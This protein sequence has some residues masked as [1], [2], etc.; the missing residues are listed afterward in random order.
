[1]LSGRA[2]GAL[3]L[4]SMELRKPVRMVRADAGSKRRFCDAGGL[5]SQ[6]IRSPVETAVGR[7]DR[8]KPGGGRSRFDQDDELRS[9]RTVVVVVVKRT[10]A[11]KTARRNLTPPKWQLP[12]PK[13]HPRLPCAQGLP[14][15]LRYPLPCSIELMSG[16]M[17][18]CDC[19]LVVTGR[20]S[21]R[22]PA[23]QPGKDDPAATNGVK[24]SYCFAA[25]GRKSSP[26]LTRCTVGGKFPSLRRPAVICHVVTGSGATS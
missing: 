21:L 3:W 20:A 12:T 23:R 2:V 26:A 18:W 14:P 22:P 25:I 6:M 15:T 17:Q 11:N 10:T 4:T 13:E 19:T 7:V 9:A 8:F 24:A 5:G 1:M 16:R